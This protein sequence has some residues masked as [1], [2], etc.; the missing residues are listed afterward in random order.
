MRETAGPLA[1]FLARRKP[2]PMFRPVLAALAIAIAAAAHAQPEALQLAGVK[3]EPVAQVGS[4]RLALNGAGIRYKLVVKVYTAGLYLAN[5]ADTPE[6]VLKAPG[7]KRMQLVMLRDIDANEFGRL[8]TRGMQDNTSRD[9]FAKSIPGTIRLG[10]MFALRKRLQAG[11]SVWIDWLPGTGTVI[12]INGKPEGEPIREPEF[13]TSLM[14]IWLGNA[15]ADHQLKDA[16]LGQSKP[17]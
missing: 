9:D 16:L 10:E 4:Q 15:P 13:Y 14:K 17:V 6:A 11:D 12:S 2:M 3:Y 8:F 5:R 7:T 1:A